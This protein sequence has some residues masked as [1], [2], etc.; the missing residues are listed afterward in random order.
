MADAEAEQ[1]AR[2]VRLPLRLDRGEEVVDRLLLPSLAAEQLVA[3]LLQPEDVGGR[4]KPAELDEFGDRLLAQPLDVERAARHEMPEPLEPLRRA[5]QAAGAA[6]VD[7]AFLGDRLALAF[8]DNGRGRRTASRASSR[9][10][11]STTCGITSPARWMRTRSPMRR[12]SRWISSR[13]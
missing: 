9:V 13:L 2:P 6:N 4:M 12:P 3:E 5:D 7:L 11:F 8:A 10:K 1:E